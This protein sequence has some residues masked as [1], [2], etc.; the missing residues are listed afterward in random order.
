MKYIIIGTAGHVDHGKTA[1]IKALTGTDTDRLKEEKARGISIDLGFASLRLGEG[2]T[3]GIVDVPGHERFLKNMLAGTGGIDMAIL[4]IAADE[5]VMPQ[6]REHLEMLEL[7]GVKQGVVVLSKVDKVEA[8]WLDLIEED[9]KQLLATTFLAK[10]PCCRVSATN[11]AGM[12]NLRQVLMEEAAKLPARDSRAP[13][14]LWIDRSFSV[15][16]HGAVVT[17]SVLS[18]KAKVG[19]V[20]K[21]YPQDSTLRVRG[22]EWHGEKVEQVLAGQ[23][24]AINL[25]GEDTADLARGMVLSAPQC[26]LTSNLWDAI[27]E[28]RQ[29]VASGTRIRLHVGT[30]EFL[31]RIYY[32]KE[33]STRY[34][35]LMLEKSLAAGLADRGL[36]RQYSP[37][38]LLGGVTL[39]GPGRKT[40][41]ISRARLNLAKIIETGDHVAII[42]SVIDDFDCPSTG[43]EIRR[44]S[45]YLQEEVLSVA[46]NKLIA[47]AKIMLA[48]SY[49]LTTRLFDEITQQLKALVG[50]CH[51]EHPERAGMSKE[52]LRQH[53]NLKERVFETM[54][55]L[56]QEKGVIAIRGAEVAIQD[57]AARHSDWRSD[58]L[59]K[60]QMALTNIGMEPVDWQILMREMQL[61]PEKARATQEILIKEGLL[62][63]IGDLQLYSKTVQDIA[64]RVRSYFVDN[65]TITVAE[66][67]DLLGISRKL[68]VPLLEYYDTH[69]YTVREGNIRHPGPKLRELPE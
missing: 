18:G 53:L 11:G 20:V 27:V 14:R 47:N 64:L 63:R 56:W 30:G 25:G 59:L 7:F 28:W 54:L 17:G 36:I 41:K 51:K 12:E 3:A 44:H 4:V 67:R 21:L 31:G 26:G 6:T 66:L 58:I 39:I 42:Y 45:G 16:G 15:K 19:D 60:A 38:I 40:R 13:F 65:P 62:I 32:F 9:V 46:L 37:Q 61:S 2:I 29:P 50:Q 8:D 68:A 23:R 24:A 1:L 22:L 52:I 34:V 43:E 33:Q 35:R 48:G 69:K 49:F 5:G 55:D 10:A 57:F